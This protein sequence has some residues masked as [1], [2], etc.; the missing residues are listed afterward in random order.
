MMV[1]PRLQGNRMNTV[2]GTEWAS[3]RPYR[4]GKSAK[5]LSLGGAALARGYFHAVLPGRKT[6]FGPSG[7]KTGF[8]R[9]SD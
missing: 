2:W 5:L 8:G 1:L 9:Q 4:A 7:R 6:G 3:H